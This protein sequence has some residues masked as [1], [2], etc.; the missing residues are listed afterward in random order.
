M[1]VHNK[2]PENNMHKY[3]RNQLQTVKSHVL[4]S[5]KRKLHLIK[6]RRLIFKAT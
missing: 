1:Q 3:N 2:M 5:R 6:I 4:I